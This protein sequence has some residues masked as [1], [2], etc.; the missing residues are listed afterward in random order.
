MVNRYLGGSDIDPTDSALVAVVLML[1]KVVE[2]STDVAEIVGKFKSAVRIDAVLG[3]RLLHLAAQAADLF[4]CG[5]VHLMEHLLIMAYPAVKVFVT[6]GGLD[7]TPSQIVLAAQYR[8]TRS[9][10]DI[11][12]ENLEDL[13]SGGI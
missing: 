10:G 1:I 12:V 2:Q 9:G 5:P 11:V 8:T 4:H 13:G 6:T 7:L 3:D